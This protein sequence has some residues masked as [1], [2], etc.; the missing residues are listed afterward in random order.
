MNKQAEI[1]IDKINELEVIIISLVS[2]LQKRNLYSSREL[3]DEIDHTVKAME[4]NDLCN[5]YP[6]HA[7]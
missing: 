4:I 3:Q 1:L 6:P 2:V 7:N 5:K